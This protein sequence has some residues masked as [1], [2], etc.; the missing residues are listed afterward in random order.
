[1]QF[2]V[3]SAYE[4]DEKLIELLK[5]IY[6]L[7]EFEIIVVDDGSSDKSVFNDV[8]KYATLL[9]HEINK[10]KG[11]ALKT[12]FN[13][14]KTNKKI[15]IVVTADAD[16]QHKV[17]DIRKVANESENNKLN[18][19]TGVRKFSGKVPLKSKI[20][21]T[22]TR[23]VF[24]LTSGLDVSDTQCGLRAFHT[25]N[26]DFML[27][28]EG[29]RYEYEMNMLTASVGI[30][31]REV[32][33]ETIYIDN[34]SSSHFNVLRDSYLIYKDLV[35]FALVSILSFIID[36]LLYISFILVFKTTFS[37][38]LFSNVLARILSATFNHNLNKKF[39]FK[40]KEKN[41]ITLPKYALLATLILTINSV[42]MLFINRLGLKNLYLLKLIVEMILF[43]VSYVCQKRFIFTSANN[44]VNKSYEYN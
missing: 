27:N 9:V 16:G 28:I 20:G 10:G 11:V 35:G 26:L 3:I 25:N 38:I 22:I 2:L 13:Y 39:V 19:I 42:L 8:K 30:G 34:N 15:G 37:K 4:P 23:K 40:N 5:N 32:E 12:A 18:L 21:N 41:S 1:M 6:E 7:D 36:Y 14:L 24:A 33:I 43:L 44:R 29:D 17:E 31:I